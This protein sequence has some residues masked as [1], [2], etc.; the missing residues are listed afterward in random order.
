MQDKCKQ[1]SFT[2][3]AK[4]AAERVEDQALCN[5]K[6]SIARNLHY[7]YIGRAHFCNNRWNL[8]GVV[9]QSTSCCKSQRLPCQP[10]LNLGIF[11]QYPP[12]GHCA[13]TL[14][15]EPSVEYLFCKIRFASFEPWVGS[16]PYFQLADQRRWN[17]PLLPPGCKMFV[18][19]CIVLFLTIKEMTKKYSKWSSCSSHLRLQELP[20]FLMLGAWSSG[21][22]KSVRVCSP[23]LS[24]FFLLARVQVCICCPHMQ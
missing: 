1:L 8:L 7:L 18:V 5:C 13:C 24:S 4:A 16:S 21:P 9:Q 6:F 3:H 23:V 14:G 22:F 2:S 10:L 17:K 15:G 20:W 12:S 11:S 19:A